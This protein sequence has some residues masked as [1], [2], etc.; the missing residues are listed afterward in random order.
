[1]KTLQTTCLQLIRRLWN[2]R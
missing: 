2:K 1:M